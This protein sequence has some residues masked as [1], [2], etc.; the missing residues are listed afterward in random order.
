[1]LYVKVILNEIKRPEIEVDSEIP[2]QL[3][4]DDD[5]TSEPAGSTTSKQ[6]KISKR[7][8]LAKAFFLDV[9]SDYTKLVWK[10]R[11]HKRRWIIILYLLITFTSSLWPY[12]KGSTQY[13]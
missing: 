9:I 11:K 12:Y 4:G 6:K 5:K 7:T 3:T 8:I 13:N 2:T 10:D 1:M